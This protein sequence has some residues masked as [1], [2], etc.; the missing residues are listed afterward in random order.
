MSRVWKQFLKNLAWPVGFAAYIVTVSFGAVYADTLFK[1][2][3][4]I[5]ATL[6]VVLPIFVYIV[7][8]MWRDAKEKVEREDQEIMRTL[9]SNDWSDLYEN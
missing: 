4:V 9:K 1:G 7:R 6:F 5:V 8:D 2:G 3:G